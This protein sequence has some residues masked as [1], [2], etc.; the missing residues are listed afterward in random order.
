M[1][2]VVPVGRP[3]GAILGGRVRLIRRKVRATC[4]YDHIPEKFEV[5]TTPLD[6]GD[7]V[8]ASEIPM[9]EGVELVYDNDYN[10]VT[11]YGKKARGEKKK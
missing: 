8:K 11:V 3:K 7:M 6:I 1:V 9:P 2:P 10:V 5:D 4:R